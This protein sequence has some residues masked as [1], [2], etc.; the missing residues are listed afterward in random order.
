MTRLEITTRLAEIAAE[1]K[2][3]EGRLAANRQ[4][5]EKLIGESQQTE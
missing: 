2:D 1:Q 5:L 4:K 3:I